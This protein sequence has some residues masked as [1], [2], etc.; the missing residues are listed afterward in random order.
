MTKM[1][2]TSIKGVLKKLVD[3]QKI[4]G[5]IFN[6]KKELKSKPQQLTELDQEFQAKKT[7]FKS[8]EDKLKSIVLQRKDVELQLKE[9][10][11]NITK[12]NAQLSQIKTNKEYSAK[13]S[14][15]ESIKADK[16]IL[17]EKILLSYDES[18]VLTVE[19]N[20]EKTVIAEEEKQFSVKKKE[21]DDQ[22]KIM[23][24]RIKV[25]ES[26]RKQYLDGVDANTLSRYEKVLNHKD[27]L[28]ITPLQNNICGGCNMMM[29][30]QMVNT[31]KMYDH[32][33]ECEI[34]SRILYLE[35]DL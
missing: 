19:I 33:V 3:L 35:D 32:L 24:D 34:C 17:E 9:K 22:I 8:L 26:Q 29:T 16:S 2:E 30:Q 10:E 1:Q 23:E 28:A 6:F 21:V 31:I 25:L 11:D 20:K 15:I 13:M 7:K 18:D 12:A 27:G 14:E 4:D 5:E